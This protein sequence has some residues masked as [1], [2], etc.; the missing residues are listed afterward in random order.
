VT[1]TIEPKILVI[2]DEESIRTMLGQALE[3]GGFRV[4]TAEDGVAGMEKFEAD[5][6]FGVILTDLMMPRMNGME[7]LEKVKQMDPDV[8]VLVLTGFGGNES[9]IEAM[10]KGAYDYLQKPTNVEELFLTVRKALERRRLSADNKKYQKNLEKLVDELAKQNEELEKTLGELKEAHDQLVQ[11]EKMASIGQ[12]SAGVAHEINNPIG[13]VHSNLGTLGKYLGKI[14]NFIDEVDSHVNNGQLDKETYQKLL[15]QEKVKFILEDIVEILNESHE[16]TLR[17]KTIVKDLKNF[18][19]IDRAQIQETS[20]EDGLDSTL[21]IVW[22]EI[23]YKAEVIKEYSDT[24]DVTCN[25]QQVNQV[26]LNLL[27]NAAH[28]IDKSPGKII[29]R[30][31][32]LKNGFVQ[33]EIEDNGSGI[34]EDKIKKI[35]DPFFTTKDIGEGTGLGLSISYRIIKDHGG[36][37]EA[38]SEIG[39]GTTF[40]ISLPVEGP[41]EK[42]NG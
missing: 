30:T 39:K 31:Q 19:N 29:I 18:S 40:R 34:E 7:V 28:A 1:D 5:D 26:F 13:F 33:I 4:E 35:F 9:A 41:P 21:N 38:F 10:K 37:I 11:S 14:K 16:G 23:K 25:P 22:N 12:L 42:S 36:E 15:K 24:P 8:E 27:V 32:D 6:S 2:D 3:I 17:V 20:L